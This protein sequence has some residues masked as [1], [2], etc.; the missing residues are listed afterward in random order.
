MPLSTC[1]VPPSVIFSPV[2]SLEPSCCRRA[3]LHDE[4]RDDGLERTLAGRVDVGVAG[5][6]GEELA[7]VLEGEAETGHRD[8]GAHAAV[9]ALDQGDHV[10]LGVRGAE[11]DGVA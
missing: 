6:E 11:G 9:V 5:L 3:V 8:A 10:A 2:G 4:T 1:T 7:A